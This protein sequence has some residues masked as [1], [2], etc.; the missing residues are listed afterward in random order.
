MNYCYL[1]HIAHETEEGASSLP[2]SLYLAL[3]GVPYFAKTL[4]STA[5]DVVFQIPK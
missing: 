4:F 5:T 1:R 2:L 3:G